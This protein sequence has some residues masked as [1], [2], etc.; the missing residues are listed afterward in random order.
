MTTDGT[1]LQLWDCNGQSN[2]QWSVT[3][4]GELKVYGNKCL[5]AA[6]GSWL[7]RNRWPVAA[8]RGLGRG[9]RGSGFT[10]P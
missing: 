3:S 1:P 10:R 8:K 7:R 5:D 4:A 9:L 6:V 2:Q